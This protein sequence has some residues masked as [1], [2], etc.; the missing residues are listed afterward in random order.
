MKIT[1]IILAAT[2]SG[3]LNEDKGGREDVQDERDTLQADEVAENDGGVD[4]E[5]DLVPVE[6]EK[7][8]EKL[9]QPHALEQ[10]VDVIK[11][12]RTKISSGDDIQLAYDDAVKAMSSIPSEGI[13]DVVEKALRQLKASERSV[14]SKQKEARARLVILEKSFKKNVGLDANNLEAARDAAFNELDRLGGL[15][16]LPPDE[17]KAAQGRIQERF[18]E[19]SVNFG[20]R[21]SKASNVR[22]VLNQLNQDLEEIWDKAD[23]DRLVKAAKTKV[24]M[25]HQGIAG[26][27][28]FQS[29]AVARI[30]KKNRGE[31]LE[32]T[33]A[34]I[35]LILG[36]LKNSI[37]DE[38]AIEKARSSL[39]ALLVGEI[40]KDEEGKK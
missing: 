35:A 22:E 9:G 20:K 2:L 14:V 21:E 6:G 26:I 34:S 32:A 27:E 15:S 37:T 39:E 28:A 29:L 8:L 24:E 31:R 18:H 12:Y 38:T 17:I 1:Y 30:E 7:S 25:D 13:E 10:V 19:F 3:C 16:V 11:A 5:D 4:Q 33:K 36:A 40:A 23:V